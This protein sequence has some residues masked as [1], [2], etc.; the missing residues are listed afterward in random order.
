MDRE[1]AEAMLAMIRQ[2]H[3]VLLVRA[4]VPLV[5]LLLGERDAARAAFEEFRHLPG[6]LE[7]GRA[8]PRS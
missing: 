5:H 6:T 7:V 2:V 3:D 1:L 4:H 8:G